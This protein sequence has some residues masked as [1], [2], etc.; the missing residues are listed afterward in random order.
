M[1]DQH[2]VIAPSAQCRQSRH[3]FLPVAVA[4]DVAIWNDQ[5]CAEC[6]QVYRAAIDAGTT[7]EIADVLVKW[8]RGHTAEEIAD[9][10]AYWLVYPFN[11]GENDGN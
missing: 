6:T 3:R 8:A 7:E 1:A 9:G 11:E 4:D 10:L 2:L 5:A